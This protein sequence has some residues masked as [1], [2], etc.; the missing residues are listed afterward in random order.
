MTGFRRRI[1][2]PVSLSEVF[3]FYCNS[4]SFFLMAYLNFW[5]FCI[6]N[7]NNE[8]TSQS[9]NASLLDWG[10]NITMHDLEMVVE[11]IQYRFYFLFSYISW[12]FWNYMEL[13]LYF[14]I[15]VILWNW[16]VADWYRYHQIFGNREDRGFQSWNNLYL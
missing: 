13:T 14:L 9:S 4:C 11:G 3:N 6:C 2:I 1:I 16:I 5:S 12:A 8:F 7:L 15:C 10:K